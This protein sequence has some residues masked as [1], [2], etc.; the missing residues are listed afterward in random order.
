[1]Y[2]M[3]IIR[4]YSV[5]VLVTIILPGLVSIIAETKSYVRGTPWSNP[6]STEAECAQTKV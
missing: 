4:G 6:K 1:M 2:H 3:C 5:K